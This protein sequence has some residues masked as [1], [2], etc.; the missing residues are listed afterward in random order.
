MVA[1][2]YSLQMFTGRAMAVPCDELKH[3]FPNIY[4]EPMQ[5]GNS[6]GTLFP[7]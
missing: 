3:K 6:E 1:P 4:M 7:I 5:M 2:T